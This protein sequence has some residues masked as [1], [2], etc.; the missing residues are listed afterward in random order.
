MRVGFYLLLVVMF[1]ESFSGDDFSATRTPSSWPL[2]EQYQSCCIQIDGRVIDFSRNGATTS[3]GQGYALF[4]ALVQNDPHFFG[5]I[6]RWTENNL[7]SGDFSQHLPAWL[8]GKGKNGVWG[9]LDQNSA[10]D[11]D[12][13]ICY[14][15]IQ[16]G[17]RWNRPEYAI[18]GIHLAHL[19]AT[20]EFGNL[21]GQ[22]EFPLGGARGFHPIPS[23]WRL[24]PSYFPPFLLRF[25][26]S[27]LNLSPW[28]GLTHRFSRM[29]ESV[30]GCGFPPDWTSF[31]Y[32]KGWRSDSVSGPL[33]SYDA[34]RVYLWA[35]MTSEQD[36]DIKTIRKSLG[37]WEKKGIAEPTMYGNGKTCQ[38]Y[39]P[40]PLGFQAAY[41][42]YLAKVDPP[43]VKSLE[44]SVRKRLSLK[45]SIGYYDYNLVLFGT[46]Y[47]ENRF[48]F[49]PRGTLHVTGDMV[50]WGKLSPI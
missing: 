48:H 29:L 14:D 39:G 5:K 8:W 22:G 23:L 6:L 32:G 25:M 41:L 10:A 30:S 31:E 3:E 2:W 50:P 45:K 20:R 9:V 27:Y 46:G 17:Q 40:A 16:A 7:S 36:P 24:N 11:A 42:P 34:I 33:G 26:E 18:K 28:K 21:P 47:L 49:G 38:G 19:I 43:K 15:L 37:G 12:L 13:W 35:G 1:L 44:R 4:F